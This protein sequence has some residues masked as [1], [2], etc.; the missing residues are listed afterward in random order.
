M[1]LSEARAGVPLEVRNRELEFSYYPMRRTNRRWGLHSMLYAAEPWGVISGSVTAGAR[2]AQ[3]AAA[4]KSFVRQAHEYFQAAGRASTIETRPL[5]YYYCFLNLAK[6]V[7]IGRGRPNLVGK[8]THGIADVGGT[9]HTVAAARVQLQRSGPRVPTVVDELHHAL[10]G[11]SVASGEYPIRDVLA[12]SVVA[13][14]MWRE[15]T[16]PLRRERFMPIDRIR[17]FTSDDARAVWTRVEIRREALESRGRTLLKTVASAGLSSDFRAVRDAAA[18]TS[19]HVIEE[20]LPHSYTGRSA[21]VV[22]DAIA[23]LRPNL[24]QTV[25][26]APPYR[27]FYLYMSEAGEARLP[28]WLSVYAVFFWLGSLTRY[29]PVELLE[30]L[31]GPYGPFFREFLETQP[32]QLL[33]MLASEAK[34][35]DVSRAAVV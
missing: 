27:R 21:D 16:H 7:A 15:A 24:W 6:A 32:T 13:H 25:T 9:P 20:Q 18:P 11:R 8:L 31:E 19:V 22:M 28:Q 2:T 14:R 34:R 29:Q 17:F 1:K 33:Y 26:S 30:A 35:Q 10:E 4:A 5:L 12:Q 3:D 23:T